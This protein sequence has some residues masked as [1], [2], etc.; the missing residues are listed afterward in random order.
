MLVKTIKVSEKGQIAIPQAMRTKLG[1]EKG[2]EL[3]VIERNGKLLLEKVSDLSVNLKDD[4][5]DL[6]VLSEKS[7]KKILDNKQDDKWGEELKNE[8]L[9]KRNH[10]V[11]VSFHKSSGKKGKARSRRVK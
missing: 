8:Y 4:F 7:L 5:G 11:S 3:L 2:S 9:A 10:P 1:V 6:L